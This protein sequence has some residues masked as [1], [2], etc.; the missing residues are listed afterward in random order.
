MSSKPEHRGIDTQP[1]ISALNLVLQ[2]Y[3]Q[4]NGVR[5]SKNKYFFPGSSQHHR[6]SLGV[7]AFRGFFMSVRPAYKQLMVNVNLCM[8]AFYVP[9]NLAQRMDEFQE[10]TGGAMPASFADRL[11][12]STRH[13][14]YTRTYVVHGIMTGK[15]ARKERFNSEEYGVMMSVEQFFKR[16][17]SSYHPV[18]TTT[19]TTD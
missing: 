2:K 10:Q 19:D 15:T 14:G 17:M 16:S 1:H 5:V 3:A 7:E 11:K 18:F 9:G 12:I 6:L 4:R 8:T 13:L